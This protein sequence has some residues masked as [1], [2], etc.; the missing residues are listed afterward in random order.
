MRDPLR[1]WSAAILS[2]AFGERNRRDGLPT[3]GPDCLPMR[4]G[5]M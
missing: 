3:L 1:R 2:R 4:G 5:P